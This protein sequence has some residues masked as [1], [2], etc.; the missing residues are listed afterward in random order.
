MATPGLGWAPAWMLK[1]GWPRPP[2]S[3]ASRD[4]EG[5]G[6]W[7]VLRGRLLPPKPPASQVLAL[8]HT[9]QGREF[10]IWDVLLSLPGE[11]LV[12]EGT[13]SSLRLPRQQ[14]LSVWTHTD[15][16]SLLALSLASLWPSSNGFTFPVPAAL[17][18]HWVM[19]AR[20][21]GHHGD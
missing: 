5:L 19:P 3:C 20:S 15:R 21:T 12:P 17:S 8:D 7:H 14:P 9:S 16:I 1:E 13:V 10:S 11:V 2:L 6:R 4:L 18:E